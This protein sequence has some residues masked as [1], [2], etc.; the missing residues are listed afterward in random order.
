MTEPEQIRVTP[1]KI[2]LATDLSSRCDRAFDRAVQLAVQWN[3]TV[4]VVHALEASNA[5]FEYRHAWDL[6]SWRRPPNPARV[7]HDRIRADLLL[8]HPQVVFDVHVEAG[9][10]AEVV[11]D[12]ILREGCDLVVTG[13]ARDDSFARFL[14]GDT[15]DRLI[16]RSPVPVL[17]VRGRGS[18]PYRNVIVATDFSPSSRQALEAAISY[19]PEAH[20]SLF[21]CYNV[22]FANY[23]DQESVG[24]EFRR[25]GNHACAKFLKETL[26][27]SDRTIGI[28]SLVEHGAPEVLL[29]QYVE[30]HRTDLVVVGS[31]GNSA[32]YD[33]FIGST[34]AKIIDAVPS[35]VLL[36]R[37]LGAV[38]ETCDR[39][40]SC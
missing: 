36:V 39:L 11:L 38:D 24:E 17:I 1:R 10:P 22:P 18:R 26:L 9:S 37:A 27:P 3:A 12:A 34:A 7:V 35:D 15:V 30:S 13:I 33:I 2:L 6:P 32:L 16:R 40:S 14:L 25:M 29:R 31:H 8:E 4:L 21:H 20:L 23:I 19:F 5:L 28:E